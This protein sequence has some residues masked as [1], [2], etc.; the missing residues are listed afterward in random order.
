MKTLLMKTCCHHLCLIEDDGSRSGSESAE[1]M[2]LKMMMM[3]IWTPHCVA[4]SEIGAQRVRSA[5]ALLETG[6]KQSGFGFCRSISGKLIFAPVC[7]W[8]E[9][10]VSMQ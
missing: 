1:Q 3:M 10:I 5:D 4:V 7:D 9:W 6:G 8:V 2:V